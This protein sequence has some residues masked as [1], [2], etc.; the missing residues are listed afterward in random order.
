MLS[1]CCA[2][3]AG[4]I[5][6]LLLMQIVAGLEPENTNLF[7]QMLGKAACMGNAADAV[8]VCP[9]NRICSVAECCS[10]CQGALV[11]LVRL[12]LLSS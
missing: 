4:V 3:V 11:Q 5:L 9:G 12:Q 7:L 8:Q 1:L 2:Q 6:L 10:P